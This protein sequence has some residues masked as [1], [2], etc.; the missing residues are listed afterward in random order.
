MRQ[1]TTTILTLLILLTALCPPVYAR[2]TA[3]APAQRMDADVQALT[4]HAHRLSGTSEGQAAGDYILAQLQAA[5]YDKPIVQTFPVTQLHREP[6]D[7]YLE[8]AGR[9]I[10]IEPLR[11]NGL[12][13]P[14]TPAEGLT[15]CIIYLKDGSDKQWRRV[16]GGPTALRNTIVLLDDAS[17][18][19]WLRAVEFG[20]AAIVFVGPMQSVGSSP[21]WLQAHANIPRFHVDA[22]VAADAGLLRDEAK[23]ITLHSKLTYRSTQGRNIAVIIPGVPGEPGA[24]SSKDVLAL[25]VEY[26]TFGPLP[27]NAP[28]PRKAANVAMLLELAR[29]WKQ[30]PPG[31]PRVLI[32]FDNG[33]QNQSGQMYFHFARQRSAPADQAGSIPKLLRSLDREQS[34]HEQSRLALS[35]LDALVRTSANGHVPWQA[36]VP[37]LV[38]LVLSAGLLIVVIW[39]VVVTVSA[40]AAK[41]R[42]WM[43]LIN[44]IAALVVAAVLI[45]WAFTWTPT[46]T[47]T[48][49]DGDALSVER[50]AFLRDLRRTYEDQ[51]EALTNL[52][53]DRLQVIDQA[54][55][56][57]R[58]AQAVTKDSDHTDS[59]V[60]RRAELTAEA[61]RLQA[62]RDTRVAELETAIDSASQRLNLL[63]AARLDASRGKVNEADRRTL[64]ALR[65]ARLG[66]LEQ[67]LAEIQRTRAE[68]ESGLTLYEALASTR[69]AALAFVDL[70][71]QAGPWA[72]DIPSAAAQGAGSSGKSLLNHPSLARALE[73]WTKSPKAR[74]LCPDLAGTLAGMAPAAPQLWSVSGQACFTLHLLDPR[75]NWPGET[76][77]SEATPDASAMAHKLVQ[78]QA[79]AE[80]VTGME[81]F[82]RGRQVA[83]TT[84]Y[85]FS[86]PDWDARA[87]RHEGNFVRRYAGGS[88]D[89]EEPVPGAIIAQGP[90]SSFPLQPLPA[91]RLGY[92][93]STA[94]GTGAFAL[95][96]D[97]DRRVVL[98]ATQT[99]EQGRITRISQ[100]RP[101]GPQGQ[102]SDWN[103]AG[104]FNAQIDNRLSLFDADSLV[105]A[106]LTDRAVFPLGQPSDLRVL[107]G[108]NE[109]PFS[110]MNLS[111]D[112]G[113]AAVYVDR[114]RDFKLLNQS[115]MLLNNW[116]GRPT[117]KGYRLDSSAFDA[118]VSGPRDVWTLNESRLAKLRE[119]GVMLDS[120]ERLHDRAE[121]WL[122]EAAEAWASDPLLARAKLAESLGY[123][124]FVHQ[125]ARTA[126][127]DMVHAVVI[128]L[129]LA[130][131]FAWALERV[132]LGSPNVYKQVGVFA[133]IFMAVFVTLYFVHPAFAFTSFP[134]V[135]LLAFLIIVLSS[136][137]IAIM[138]GRFEH[139]IKRLQGLAIA[140]HRSTRNV[141]STLAA[142][143]AQGVASMRRRPLRTTLTGVTIALLTFTVM[144]FGS[145]SA[146]GGFQ[147]VLLGP[148]QGQPRVEVQLPGARVMNPAAV[149]NLARIAGSEPM[150]ARFT[151]MI[152]T[153]RPGDQPLVSD[154]GTLVGVKSWMTLELADLGLYA[155]LRESLSGD[156][157]TLF[158][159]PGILL[160]EG[161][162]ASNARTVSFLGNTWPVRGSFNPAKLRSVTSDSG[163][164]LVPPDVAEMTRLLE[165]QNPNDPEGVRRIM[166]Q[167]ETAAF[168][169]IDPQAMVLLVGVKPG[170]LRQG[171]VSTLIFPAKDDATAHVI[172]QSLTTILRE[173]VTVIAGGRAERMLYT[174]QVQ[175]SGLA[176]LLPPLV[177]GGLIIFGTM[178]SSVTDRER[179]IY[180]LAAL[181]LS[182]AHVGVLFFAEAL[183]YS[184]LGGVS[185]Y[186]LGQFCARLAES[187]ASLGWVAAPAVNTSSTDAMLAILLVMVTVLLSTIYPAYKASRSANPGVQ[188][189]WRLPAPKGD[190]LEVEFPFTVSGHDAIGLMMFLEEFLVAHRDRS[191]GAF[192]A[193]DVQVEHEAGRFIV[194]AKIWLQPF[195]QGVS[196]TF[197]LS[198]LPSDIEGIDRVM[199]VMERLS[200]PPAVWRR[201]NAIFVH[202]LRQQFIFWRTIDQ[203]AGEHYHKMSAE[204]F[205]LV[206]T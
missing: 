28:S 170:S 182:P 195:D 159:Q 122:R 190:R 107:R 88:T 71:P 202:E 17:G 118:L 16:T 68:L 157:T 144:F 11:P 62:Q 21:K 48:G 127:T 93:L 186:L 15:G 178:L 135:V 44:P 155:N 121:R 111:L 106:G 24:K 176:T 192:A 14:I 128:L 206:E 37:T 78:V 109:T 5:G 29:Q 163:M 55:Q 149:R 124:A 47:N 33:A 114:L 82:P 189:S 165:L 6:G 94:W 59:P 145:L 46:A 64:D 57:E 77:P 76:T 60:D 151:P 185:G 179:E 175:I 54:R 123:S 2:Q 51:V 110:R 56:A 102:A 30:T 87:R 133:A 95:L 181:G 92:R 100:Y 105:I 172:A 148:A 169:I 136:L 188:R 97:D 43:R 7:C 119:H 61:A 130:V 18:D 183:V 63:A 137:V 53:L 31:T 104:F 131:P 66:R 146:G 79:W 23:T 10:D 72:I 101:T 205:Q 158:D 86:F 196:Q 35:D 50:S 103:R 154:G 4:R 1:A 49:N 156:V 129:L 41:S 91:D 39:L 199:L 138:W 197:S 162:A 117:G 143:F 147:Q 153:N 161:S 108:I 167:T 180:T 203:E 139:E 132:V 160:P 26:D 113:V 25:A 45:A 125:P 27:W 36:W 126:A 152:A 85:Y 116:A 168:P 164:R 32:F 187:L 191:V 80:Q 89:A 8:I 177:L 98:H 67:R 194:R 99:D 140:S 120:V 142:A 38:R 69:I 70:A 198:T 52:R 9:R 174:H 13:L 20:A 42:G 115:Q 166:E 84:T 184:L 74:E 200:G 171:A 12:A 112:A 204:R 134:I 201:G 81:S 96:A 22:K 173:P 65:V 3:T 90:R 75:L 83:R 19:A 73:N 141:R 193:A 150:V 40:P 34:A 58:T